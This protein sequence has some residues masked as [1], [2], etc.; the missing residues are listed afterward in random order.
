MPIDY[1][2]NSA[3]EWDRSEGIGAASLAAFGIGVFFVLVALLSHSGWPLVI[4]ASGVVGGILG[5]IQNLFD[6]VVYLAD[7]ESGT[8]IVRRIV[9]RKVDEEF[10]LPLNE[11]EH[12][13]VQHQDD[14]R[15][16]G[17]GVSTRIVAKMKSGD[18]IPLVK[19]FSN[20]NL[21]QKTEMLNRKLREL[22]EQI[23]K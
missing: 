23:V 21:F 6:V 11:I 8:F 20:R 2:R 13:E 3:I 14:E 12:F 19:E 17:D 7:P 5:M 15:W 22:R 18:R 9:W 4:G 1:Y 16:K 10:T